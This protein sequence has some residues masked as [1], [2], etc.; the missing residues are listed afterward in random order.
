LNAAIADAH[1]S[2]RVIWALCVVGFLS[3]VT[4]GARILIVPLYGS[5]LG[6]SAASIGLLYAVFAGLSAV[7]SFPSGILLDRGH[8]RVL[9]AVGLTTS[10]VAQ[11]LTI[12]TYV[13]M[14]A[15]AQVLSGATLTVIQLSVVTA[16]INAAPPRQM[17]RT[18]GMVAVAAQS[19]LMAGPALAGALLSWV[20]FTTLMVLSAGPALVALAISLITVRDFGPRSDDSHEVPTS[21]ELLKNPAIRQMAILAVAMGTL[22]GTFQAYFAIFAARGLLMPAVAIGWLVALAGLANALSRIPAGRLLSRGFR[23]DAIIAASVVG[24]AAGLAVLPHLWGFW[25]TALLIAVTVP[26]A[27]LGIMGMSVALAELGGTHGRG[28]AISIM[29]L[30]FNVASA[31]APAILASA[32]DNS[33]TVGFAAASLTGAAV[34]GVALLLHSNSKAREQ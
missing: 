20:G 12:T 3:N 11:V 10:A 31:A 6:L 27:S 18:I 29:Y 7:I 25:L 15:F 14:I 32:M 22:W 13:P 9:L 23:K 33:F 16:A 26:L 17:G 4:I 34:A 8:T 30:V 1:R 19:G 24:F 21:R 5:H 2:R 28:R